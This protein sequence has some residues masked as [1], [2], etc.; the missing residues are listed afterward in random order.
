[1]MMRLGDEEKR[2]V[3]QASSPS[4]DPEGSGVVFA[5]RRLGILIPT[6]PILGSPRCQCVPIAGLLKAWP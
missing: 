6:P 2:V 5:P 3:V 1:M 4:L